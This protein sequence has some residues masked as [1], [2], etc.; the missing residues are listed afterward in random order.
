MRAGKNDPV[1]GQGHFLVIVPALSGLLHQFACY[2]LLFPVQDCGWLLVVFAL[3]KLPDNTF[4]LNKSFET[5]N[6]FFQ[7]L[8]IIY[9]DMRQN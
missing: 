3:F 7:H 2:G 6:G 8:V 4:F 1:R 5:L 9:D